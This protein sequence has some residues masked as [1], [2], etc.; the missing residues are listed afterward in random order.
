M[1]A[2]PAFI[3]ASETGSIQGAARVL[4]T[5]RPTIRARLDQLDAAIGVPLLVRGTRGRLRTTTAGAL[6]AARAREILAELEGLGHAVRATGASPQG[7]LRVGV[8][9]GVPP[10]I[11]AHMTATVGAMWPEVRLELICDT[12]DDDLVTR[13]DCRFAMELEAPVGSV[14]IVE[15]GT[16]REQLIASRAYLE[17]HDPI[18]TVDDLAR[19]PLFVWV[20]PDTGAPS[21]LPV[22]RG[23][24]PRT[25]VA[26]A[27]TDLRSLLWL[28]C[29]GRGLV[30][31]PFE[32]A[33]ARLPDLAG[34]DLTPVLPELVGRDRPRRLV[35]SRA[36]VEMPVVAAFLEQTRAIARQLFGA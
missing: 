27:T 31:L 1:E 10:Q 30:F 5:A 21:R 35:V 19:H 13:V 4:H 33:L 12:S 7:V 24:A 11:I 34:A 23:R 18:V 8:P 20:A 3:A 2:I 32:P 28:A 25:R 15:L 22:L 9:A 17:A 29:E 14:E 26:M 16:V 36:V 6:F